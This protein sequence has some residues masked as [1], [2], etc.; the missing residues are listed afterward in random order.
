MAIRPQVSTTSPYTST[1]NFPRPNLTRA[2]TTPSPAQLPSYRTS[3]TFVHHSPS[4][5]SKLS[6]N[7]DNDN[8]NDPSPSP[9]SRYSRVTLCTKKM[10]LTPFGN[11]FRTDRHRNRESAV[12]PVPP[13]N[14][15]A[16]MGVNPQFAH[17]VRRPESVLHPLRGGGEGE[18]YRFRA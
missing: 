17:W 16:P 15:S 7:N 3:P 8:D 18:K 12:P 11:H 13:L 10:I 14:I 1:N 4:A 9:T 5:S 6:I 2:E